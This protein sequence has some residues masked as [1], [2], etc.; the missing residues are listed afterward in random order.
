MADSMQ[1]QT[2]ALISQRDALQQRNRQIQ[3]EM[4]SLQSQITKLDAEYEANNREVISIE[5][6]MRK[7]L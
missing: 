2:Q 6:A 4:V 1:Q 3:K 5:R 7:L